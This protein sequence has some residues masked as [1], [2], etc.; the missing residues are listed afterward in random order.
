MFGLGSTFEI[1]RRKT[2]FSGSNMRNALG[3]LLARP[4]PGDAKPAAFDENQFRTRLAAYLK[5]VENAI[6][7]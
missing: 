3:Q 2:H 5:S 7:N 1:K 4:Q 6:S